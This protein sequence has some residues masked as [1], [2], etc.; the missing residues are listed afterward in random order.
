[1][2]F[3]NPFIL[4]LAIYLLRYPQTILAADDLYFLKFDATTL[5]GLAEDKAILDTFNPNNQQ[6]YLNEIVF[7]EGQQG[8]VGAAPL[9]ADGPQSA[10]T[11]SQIFHLKKHQPPGADDPTKYHLRFWNGHRI[12]Q[13]FFN[14]I[15][16]MWLAGA[17]EIFG[18]MSEKE[19]L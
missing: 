18:E 9:P 14:G 16:S 11:A 8:I 17:P 15:P 6:I 10:T 13:S 2:G 5:Q 4:P 3:R 19:I 7:A 12:G 1:M